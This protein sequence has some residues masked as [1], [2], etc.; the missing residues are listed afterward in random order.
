MRVSVRRAPDTT[1]LGFPVPEDATLPF[2]PDSPVTCG[3]IP[4]DWYGTLIARFAESLNY[5]STPTGAHS[6]D[7]PL[8]PRMPVDPAARTAARILLSDPAAHPGVTDLAAA[9]FVSPST[10]TRRFRAETGLTV[11]AWHARLRL[12]V[13]AG[14]LADG[15]TVESAAHHVGLSSASTLCRLARRHTGATPGQL[16]DRPGGTPVAGGQE[17]T[18]PTLSTWPRVNRFHVLLWAWRGACRVTVADTTTDLREGELIWLPAGLPNHI[19]MDPGAL[20]LP[21]G[22]RAGRPSGDLAPTV[23]VAEDPGDTADTDALLAALGREY[24]PVATEQT[25]VVDRLFY[26]FLA[27]EVDTH[28]SRLLRRI[29]GDFRRHPGVDRTPA[30]W[31]ELLDCTPVELTRALRLSGADS[32]RQWT[33]RVRMGAAR[34]LLA[35]GIPVGAV[36]RHLGYSGTASFSHV[37]RRA[38]GVSPGNWHG[39]V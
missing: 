16:R 18:P 17:E 5:L 30:Q 4:D 8:L 15:C 7:R 32:V 36:A 2:T 31:A 35:S 27:G 24:D 9:V 23:I 14:L 10:L 20:V 13:A 28:G 11:S 37:F 21:V 39:Y 33:A 26:G 12:S 34:R 29:S 1:A 22:A 3:D 6:G 38:H 25:D 19:D